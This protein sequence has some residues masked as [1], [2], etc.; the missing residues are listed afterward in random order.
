ML[1]SQVTGERLPRILRVNVGGQPVEWLSWQEAVCLYARELVVWTLGEPVLRV[2]GGFSRIHQ[3]RTVL[4]LHSIIACDGQVVPR[5]KPVPPLTNRALFRRDQNL[6]MYCGN[7]FLDMHLTR[8]HVVPRSRGGID[9]W[10][11]VVAAC[12]RCNH[13][14]GNRLLGEID[15]DLKAL[16]YAPN[17]AEYLALINSGRILGDQMAFLKAQFGRD[18]RLKH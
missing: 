10:D 15:M 11:N 16:P 18:S 17:F 7:E 5:A 1:Q 8:D 14:K 12:K 4:D 13:H 2:R 6:C 3:C 9:A